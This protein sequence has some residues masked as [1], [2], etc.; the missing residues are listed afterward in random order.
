MTHRHGITKLT[1]S[2]PKG[3]RTAM[4]KGLATSLLE[5][6]HVVTTITKAKAVLPYVERVITTSK[7][8]NLHSKRMV[9][10]MV[11]SQAAWNK[12]VNEL[13]KR[14]QDRSGGYVR[15]KRAGFRLGDNAALM[16]LE[17]IPGEAEA[18]TK[19]IKKPLTTTKATV[20]AKAATKSGQKK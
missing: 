11:S 6:E 4:V 20:S 15:R 8:N 10:S 3:H 18:E 16:R 7:R 14:Y 19:Q 2:R 1:L 13:A 9:A 12:A 5:H 17:L